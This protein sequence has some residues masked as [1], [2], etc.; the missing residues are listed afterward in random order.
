MNLIVGSPGTGLHAAGGGRLFSAAGLRPH[1]GSPRFEVYAGAPLVSSD[2]NSE[3]GTIYEGTS[4]MQLQTIAKNLLTRHLKLGRFPSAGRMRESGTRQD[5]R[6]SVDSRNVR[7]RSSALARP[8]PHVSFRR[9]PSGDAQ[10]PVYSRSKPTNSTS[11]RS[12]A[13]E[14]RSGE[15]SVPNTRSLA[16]AARSP[17]DDRISSS[18]YR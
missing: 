12:A 15:A 14:I 7:G 2:R 6:G 13:F 16:P 17:S 8:A 3:N 9:R 10:L 18:R 11:V 1:F 5:G 4:N